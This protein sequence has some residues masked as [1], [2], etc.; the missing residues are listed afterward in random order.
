[1][2]IH[3]GDS[4]TAQVAY[5][6]ARKE[7]RLSLIDHTRGEH[8]SRLR[9]CPTVKVSGKRVTCPRSSAEVIAEAPAIQ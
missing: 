7:F 1:M 3:A 9:T 5:N 8:A 4:V 2:K 6:P